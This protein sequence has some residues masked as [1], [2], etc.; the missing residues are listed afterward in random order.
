MSNA[1]FGDYIAISDLSV[2]YIADDYKHIRYENY[3]LNI[4]VQFNRDALLFAYWLELEYQYE[5][6][7]ENEKIQS[8]NI[9][10]KADFEYEGETGIASFVIELNQFYP[11]KAIKI[12]AKRPKDDKESDIKEK[13]YDFTQVQALKN[14]SFNSKNN[15]EVEYYSDWYYKSIYPSR[16]GTIEKYPEIRGTSQEQK[17]LLKMWYDGWVAIY[18]TKVNYLGKMQFPEV[19]FGE[20][21][22]PQTGPGI[23]IKNKI[24]TFK[25]KEEKWYFFQVPT[26]GFEYGINYLMVSYAIGDY[27][28]DIYH[29]ELQ[30]SNLRPLSLFS[31]SFSQ[32]TINNLQE[33][34]EI[35]EKE[36]NSNKVYTVVNKPSLSGQFFNYDFELPYQFPTEAQDFS[37]YIDQESNKKIGTG[38]ILFVQNDTGKSYLSI[39]QEPDFKETKVSSNGTIEGEIYKNNIAHIKL[40]AINLFTEIEEEVTITFTFI[41][42]AVPIVFPEFLKPYISLQNISEEELCLSDAA[43]S[44]KAQ[45]LQPMILNPYE[46]IGYILDMR[47]VYIPYLY[48]FGWGKEM[49]SFSCRVFEKIVEEENEYYVFNNYDN[50]DLYG[51]PNSD[52]TVIIPKRE[53]EKSFKSYDELTIDKEKRPIEVNNQNTIHSLSF[54]HFLKVGIAL[55]WRSDYNNIFVYEEK[56]QEIATIRLGR[57]LPL[58]FVPEQFSFSSKKI[59]YKIDDYG[60]DKTPQ[61]NYNMDINS[62]TRTGKE[63]LKFS[64]QNSGN[65]EIAYILIQE[66]DSLKTLLLENIKREINFVKFPLIFSEKQNGTKYTLEDL[67]EVETIKGKYYF[68][69]NEPNEYQYIAFSIENITFNFEPNP[70]FGFRKEGIIINGEPEQPLKK[71]G[72]EREDGIY[73]VEINAILDTDRIIINFPSG[74][75][76]EIYFDPTRGDTGKVI[77]KGFELE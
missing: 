17:T 28:V 56:V 19:T 15:L 22:T 1:S 61:K 54:T 30:T 60:G 33:I 67:K 37:V 35:I 62:L 63:K 50:Y 68:Y 57:T 66:I 44:Q 5:V 48:C 6:I 70:S 14:L 53:G 65:E 18:P 72:E 16:F 42:N 36:E 51:R 12:R 39:V 49:N 3:G 24:A 32:P 75:S 52:K 13:T 34:V 21:K 59:K 76:G 40:K 77:L 46:K 45:L 20:T 23:V 4:K 25:P 64:L 8:T 69:F 73:F 55:S 41:L 38:K 2:D 11:I 43:Y 74:A 31:R 7:F 47:Y 9:W 29:T 27:K 58:N 10:K 26:K 71:I